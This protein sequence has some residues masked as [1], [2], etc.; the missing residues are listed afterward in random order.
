MKI[1]GLKVVDAVKPMILK[2]TNDDCAKGNKKKAGSCAAARALCRSAKVEEARVHIG[3]VYVKAEGKWTR[4]MPSPALRSEI[5]AFDRGG[6]F[7][8]GEYKLAA[9]QPSVRAN[10]RKK[11]KQKP[12]S[13]RL[14]GSRPQKRL[15]PHIV[16][17]IRD[18]ASLGTQYR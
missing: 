5:I 7:E 14:D 2:I 8:P 9:L 17:G 13:Q 4:Y 12:L 6:K 10:T 3:R 18:R 11:R 15:K 16:S 1:D